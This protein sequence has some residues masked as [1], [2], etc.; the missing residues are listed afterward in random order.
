M[1]FLKQKRYK[2]IDPDEIFLDASNL[3]KFDQHQLEGR[4][5]K[6]L[7]KY[8]FIAVGIFVA[9]VFV[10]FI[11]RV[12]ELQVVRGDEFKQASLNNRLESTIIFSE[13]GIMV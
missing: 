13:R 10:V 11:S 2:D 4:I 12:A 6:P 3:P 8:P 9:V 1:T 7:S 5:E